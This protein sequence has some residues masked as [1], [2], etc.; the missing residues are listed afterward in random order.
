MQYHGIFFFT[1]PLK[2]GR[3]QK[4]E[5]AT[6]GMA[7]SNSQGLKA[8]PIKDKAQWVPRRDPW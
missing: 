8:R 5:Q 6:H 3:P 4:K 1:H 7:C 2:N